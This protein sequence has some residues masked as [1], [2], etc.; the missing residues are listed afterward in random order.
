MVRRTR[1]P[2]TGDISKMGV[3]SKNG[4]SSQNGDSSVPPPTDSPLPSP[5]EAVSDEIPV[6]DLDH[7]IAADGKDQEGVGNISSQGNKAARS[8]GRVEIA[9]MPNTAL[10]T[11]VPNESALQPP[12]FMK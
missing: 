8:A 5:T 12:G 11:S 6:P 10:W 7:A 1:R 2:D 4:D 9:T 3:N